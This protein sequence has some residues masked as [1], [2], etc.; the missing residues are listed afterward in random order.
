[1]TRGH[2]S[3]IGINASVSLVRLMRP[4]EP[5]R[6]T[7]V[8]DLF[9]LA[10][11]FWGK[12]TRQTAVIYSTIRSLQDWF[13][14]SLSGKEGVVKPGKETRIGQGKTIK[15]QHLSGAFSLDSPTP[16]YLGARL[17]MAELVD[18]QRVVPGTDDIPDVE[19]LNT[20][21]EGEMGAFLAYEAELE[22]EGVKPGFFQPAK[23]GASEISLHSCLL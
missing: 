8:L 6:H 21:G 3:Q 12:S 16:A 9:G 4:T 2:F 15:Q 10:G 20:G 1:M 14:R 17:A 5:P 23:V 22:R 11:R 18:D 13:P 19:F 7:A